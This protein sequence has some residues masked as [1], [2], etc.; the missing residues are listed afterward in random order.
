MDKKSFDAKKNNKIHYF[1]AKNKVY[2]KVIKCLYIDLKRLHTK[3]LNK[4]K[5]I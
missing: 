1:K 5:T 3:T 2:V 4:L